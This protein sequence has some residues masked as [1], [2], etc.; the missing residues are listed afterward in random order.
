MTPQERI[1]KLEALLRRVRARAAEPR[2]RKDVSPPMP[3]VLPPGATTTL[4]DVKAPDFS[5]IELA[6]APP[7]PP[8]IAKR[9]PP[10][11]R[12]VPRAPRPAPPPSPPAPSQPDAVASSVSRLR[13]AR[14]AADENAPEPDIPLEP[15]L[16]QESAPMLEVAGAIEMDLEQGGADVDALL[17]GGE[18][19]PAPS[20]SPRPVGPPPEEKLAAMAFGEEPPP[21]PELHTPPPESG[22]LPAAPELAD[23]DQD[24]TGVREAPKVA[25]PPPRLEPEVTAPAIE[26]SGPVA[27]FVGEP[28]R[29][30]PETIGDLLDAT[31]S[32]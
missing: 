17:A 28:A 20:S 9:P 7:A 32:L 31:M 10:V 12:P 30:R 11:P 24:I 8:P 3:L 19:E 6:P 14:P 27:D 29:F 26:A 16:P 23:F 5:D 15:R 22:R 4:V 18:E 2:D 21:M 13:S 1:A 25:A